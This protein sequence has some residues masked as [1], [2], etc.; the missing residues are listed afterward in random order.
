[1]KKIPHCL[2]CNSIINLE[3]NYVQFKYR[4]GNRDSDIGDA[5]VCEACAKENEI[6]EIHTNDD[7]TES[8]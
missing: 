3:S 8:I 5:Y 2:M 4:Y 6:D 7:E 1:M